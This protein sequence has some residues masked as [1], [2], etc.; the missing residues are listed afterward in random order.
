MPILRN[1]LAWADPPPDRLTREETEWAH[2]KKYRKRDLISQTSE[3]D[4]RHASS[5]IQKH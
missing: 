4:L 5:K 3:A 1:P 2:M